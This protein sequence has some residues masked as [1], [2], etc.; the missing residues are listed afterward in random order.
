[1]D[2]KEINRTQPRVSVIV[3]LFD[4]ERTVEASLRSAVAQTFT[5]F[6]ILVVDDGS[7]DS[8]P[9]LVRAFPDPR[10]RLIQQENAGPGAA[11][12][13]GIAEARGGLLAFL[14]ADDQWMPDYLERAIRHLDAEPEIAAITFSWVDQPVGVS[15]VPALQRRGLVGGIQPISPT[16]APSVMVAMIILMWPVTTV[17]RAEV[18]RRFGGFYEKGARYGEDGHLFVKVLLNEPVRFDLQ[19]AAHFYRNASSLSGNRRA[20]RP[21]EPFLTD[22]D[23]LRRVCPEPLRDLLEGFLC[24][25]ALKTSCTLAYWGHWREGAALRRRFAH[26]R[27]RWEPLRFVSLLATTPL[28]ALAGRLARWWKGIP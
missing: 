14:D 28:G 1:M 12:N 8:G 2:A 7:R 10:I 11:R 13:R 16:L 23:D 18:V 9:T 25:R 24:M 26:P 4:K 17:V 6:E 22:P 19:P 27:C 21:L 15:C 20:M 5:D 3:P